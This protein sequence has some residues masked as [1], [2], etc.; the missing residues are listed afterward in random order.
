MVLG[1]IAFD[2]G[3]ALY[4]RRHWLVEKGRRVKFAHGAMYRFAGAPFLLCT[5]HPSQQNTFTGRL[6]QA[7]L[8]GVFRRAR[9][10]L[11]RS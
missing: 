1:K 11:D 8:R 4:K 10:E 3:V 2:A 9:E 7:M 5:Y 6:T